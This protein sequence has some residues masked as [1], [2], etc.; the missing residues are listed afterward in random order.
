[1][2]SCRQWGGP[3]NYLKWVNVAWTQLWFRN[4]NAEAVCREIRVGE[5]HTAFELVCWWHDQQGGVRERDELIFWE[6]SLESE[7]ERRI[8]EPE[9]LR[10]GRPSYLPQEDC[11]CHWGRF[12]GGWLRFKG[13][14][15]ACHNTRPLTSQE[16]TAMSRQ[17]KDKGHTINVSKA[18]EGIRKTCHEG[19]MDLGP[20]GIDFKV[21]LYWQSL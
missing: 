17:L 15:S 21:S 13:L 16:I 20:N 8:V 14:S 5:D 18:F 3:E 9:G 12:H 10:L 7:G 1:M 4:V 11:P 19:K 6:T 2:L